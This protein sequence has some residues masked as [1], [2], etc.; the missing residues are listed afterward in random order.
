MKD[1]LIQSVWRD[2]PQLIA[3]ITFLVVGY[4][5]L[6]FDSATTATLDLFW[7]LFVYKSLLSLLCVPLAMAQIAGNRYWN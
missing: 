4:T 3:I 5:F 1:R 6:A 2:Y 7:V